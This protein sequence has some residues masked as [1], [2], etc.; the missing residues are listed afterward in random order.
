MNDKYYGIMNT[1]VMGIVLV[2][3]SIILFT[4]KE[5][6]YMASIDF[7]IL[8]FFLAFIIDIYSLCFRKNNKKKRDKII[9][10]S[11]FHIGTCLFFYFVPNLFYGIAPI[12]FSIYLS[13]IGI[14]QVVMCYVMVRNGEYIRIHNVII[15]IIC[16]SISLP[17][18]INPVMRL[19][20]F[21]ICIGIYFILLGIYY[22]YDFIRNILP[23]RYKN[24]I[25][26]RIRITLPKILEAIIPYSVMQE[27]N[28]NLEIKETSSYKVINTPRKIDL[29]ILIHT[30]NRGVNRMGHMDIYFDGRVIS[31]GNYDEGSRFFYEFFGDG[32]LFVAKKKCDYINFCIDNSK[33]TIFEFGISLTDEEMVRV[34][35]RIDELL[36]STV[37]WDQ[38]KD[39]KYNDGDSYAGRLYKRTKAMF[40]K[41]KKGKYKT[42]FVMGSNCCHLIDDI[43]G[44]SGMDIL[45][46]NGIITPGTYY[47]YLSRML[48]VK[49]SN[50]LS[51]NIY[52]SRY[53]A[54]EEGDK[55]K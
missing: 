53:R 23:I 10:N 43:V 17:I 3:L 49:G 1:L 31:Y 30:S 52:N 19:D 37:K 7:I 39:L 40:Y 24:K 46:I 41:F 32:V 44:S 21:V 9:R 14:S 16:F 4:Y 18:F 28:R 54:G 20:R 2:V 5:Q 25:K 35:R 27:I 13:L 12:M 51:L 33:K 11:I 26:R 15:G 29:S 34:R 55:E 36:M 50:V 8:L 6:F 38:R 47:D 22:L 48:K 45:S 42:Y